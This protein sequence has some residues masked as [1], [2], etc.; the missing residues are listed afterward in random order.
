MRGIAAPQHPGW[1]PAPS[2]QGSTQGGVLQAKTVKAASA[3]ASLIKQ[4]MQAATSLTQLCELL[5][6]LAAQPQPHDVAIAYVQAVHLAQ[7]QS[8]LPSAAQ[9]QLQQ[10]QEQEQ[11]QQQQLH[12]QHVLAAADTSS[13]ISALLQGL[14]ALV[15][16]GIDK[17]VFG[18]LAAVVWAWA[19]L[20]HV[21]ERAVL[22]AVVHRMEQCKVKR[23]AKGG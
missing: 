4:Q 19:K 7:G 11:Q 13:P 9:Q 10:E 15:L 14:D 21:P 2:D 6:H 12:R 3:A 18:N 23:E 1:L 16:A 5:P 22:R 17:F 20:G 8:D